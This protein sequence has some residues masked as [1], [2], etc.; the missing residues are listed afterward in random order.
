M[1]KITLLLFLTCV[2]FGVFAQAPW[3]LSGNSTISGDFIGTTSTTPLELKTTNTG[4]PQ[5]INFYTN[6]T[7]KA[8][9][10]ANGNFGVGLLAPLYPLDVQDNINVNTTGFLNGYRINGFTVLQT[11]ALENVFVGRGSAANFTGSTLGQNTFVGFNAGGS[12]IS[13]NTS[14][15]DRNTFVG[16]AAGFANVA[17]RFNTFIGCDAGLSLVSGNEN[18]FVG[19]HAGFRQVSG[20]NNTYVGGH[21][22]Q[23][24][25]NSTGSNNTFTG[26][27]CG[28]AVNNGNENT[29]A[30]MRAG[31][32][33]STG[34]QNCFY[35]NFSGLLTNGGSRNVFMGYLADRFNRGGNDNTF[36]GNLAGVPTG[37]PFQNLNNANGFGSGATATASNTMILGDNS[38]NVGI[39]LSGNLVS[40]SNKLEINANAANLSGLTFRQLPGASASLTAINPGPGVLA[41]GTNG[42]VIYVPAGTANAL[43]GAHNGTSLSTITPNFVAW[44]QNVGQ[45]GN[46]GQLLNNR[47]IPQNQFNIQF[48]DGAVP[49]PGLNRISFGQ[50]IPVAQSTKFYVFNNIERVG[51]TFEMDATLVPQPVSL[52]ETSVAS[53]IIGLSDASVT[54]IA[55]LGNS[56]NLISK[57]NIGVAGN[58]LNGVA[59]NIGVMGSVPLN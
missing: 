56:N 8:T 6:N 55:V 18:T 57:A 20:D 33:C 25:L 32:N 17:G 4:T 46:P 7:Q 10:L 26:A 41:L 21:S 43:V 31:N 37:I 28:P 58:A 47:E 52:S 36:V 12:Y 35:G 3:Y 22:G 11:P 23:G 50:L 24:T 53:R 13:S 30:G 16:R 51:A 34:D 42:E 44:G 54:G 39:G 45:A 48:I 29:F 14:G 19:E 1:N 9:I 59:E 15:G 38:V 27:F 5:P 40:P 49:T 2:S